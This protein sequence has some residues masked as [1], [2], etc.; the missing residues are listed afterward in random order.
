MIRRE[1]RPLFLLD[2]PLPLALAGAREAH[3]SGS[4]QGNL[5]QGLG[6]ADNTSCDPLADTVLEAPQ[7]TAGAE[8]GV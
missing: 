7:N 6:V 5:A 4:G 2:V 1:K 8:D 3:L